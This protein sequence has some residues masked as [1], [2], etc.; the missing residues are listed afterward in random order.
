[1]HGGAADVPEGVGGAEAA[2]A[3][4]LG[5]AQSL[6]GRTVVLQHQGHRVADEHGVVKIAEIHSVGLLHQAA[7]R[8][9][10]GIVEAVVG[11][12]GQIDGQGTG[13]R[14]RLGGVQQAA[15]D[16][17][18]LLPG[19]VSGGPEAAVAVAVDETA[20]LAGG[21]GAAGVLANVEGVQELAGIGHGGQLQL[22]HPGK[23]DQ[24]GAGVLP[25]DG[26]VGVEGRGADAVD[27]AALIGPADGRVIGMVLG[28]VGE[29]RVGAGGLA[30]QRQMHGVESG[31][32]LQPGL[33]GRGPEG[34]GFGENARLAQPGDVAVAPLRCGHIG[35]GIFPSCFPGLL[36]RNRQ[37]HRRG[38]DQRRRTRSHFFHISAPQM[39]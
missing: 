9:L 33:L 16:C 8:S 26:A 36:R 21:D 11:A 10:V 22:F 31:H 17:R 5:V 20:H 4:E 1:M 39:N 2:G 12:V 29:G 35:I 13:G 37:N 25:G 19:D 15:E 24:H 23:A 30:A 34:A 3:E 18:A 14:L 27:H 38:K 32:Q 28:H 7:G 6:G